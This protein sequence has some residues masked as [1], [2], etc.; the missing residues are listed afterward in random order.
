MLNRYCSL[1]SNTPANL[2][3]RLILDLRLSIPAV[4]V[5][6]C[7]QVGEDLNALAN[8]YVT[9]IKSLASSASPSPAP[10]PDRPLQQANLRYRVEFETH[11]FS[12]V[13]CRHPVT[14]K[15]LAVDESK[16]RGWWLPAGHVDRGQVPSS[17]TFSLLS[18]GIS[19]LGG[20]PL[21]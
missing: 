1:T 12:V 17:P 2:I 7:M 6:K 11:G 20:V 21:L 16:G 13:V 14:K 8:E 15:W 10:G 18:S 4:L 3:K 19:F 9:T 5:K